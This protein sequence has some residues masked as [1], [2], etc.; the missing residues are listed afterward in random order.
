LYPDF[1]KKKLDPGLLEP[2]EVT[3]MMD[4]CITFP[5]GDFDYQWPDFDFET[6]GLTGLEVWYRG[7]RTQERRWEEFTRTG[8]IAVWPF[9]HRIDYERTIDRS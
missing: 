5:E 2:E 8:D 7:R 3:A 1:P 6:G 9:F 4:R